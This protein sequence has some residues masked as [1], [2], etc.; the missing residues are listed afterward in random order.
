MMEDLARIGGGPIVRAEA[1]QV[2]VRVLDRL[3]LE[4]VVLFE[5]SVVDEDI[6]HEGYQPT[7]DLHLAAGDGFGI[8]LLPVLKPRRLVMQVHVNDQGVGLELKP[9]EAYSHTGVRCRVHKRRQGA[10]CRI[11]SGGNCL[12]YAAMAAPKRA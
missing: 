10:P 5:E 11:R 9:R 4:K 12:S 8:L 6:S 7:A 1:Q 2:H 3:R